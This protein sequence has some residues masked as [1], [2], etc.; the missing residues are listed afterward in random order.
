MPSKKVAK[1]V[2]L[3]DSPISEVSPAPVYS[4]HIPKLPKL[5]NRVVF[6]LILAIVIV[7]GAVNFKHLAVAA[8]V[9][10]KPI[11]RLALIRDLEKQSGKQALDNIITKQLILQEA[12]KQGMAVTKE[13]I[14]SKIATTK[15][16]VEAQGAK[17]DDI[18]ASQG[19][20]QRDLEDQFSV[21]LLI[22]KILSKDIKVE[23][24]EIS[25]YFKTNTSFFPKGTKLDEVKDSIRD[26]L[27]QQKINQKFQEWVTELKK[28]AKIDYWL[29]L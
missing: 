9:N 21:Q 27:T 15:K 18:L 12:A 10:G 8:I 25:D 23:D 1:K 2:D 5:N 29:R 19:I 26:T 17:W 11:S 13:E 28:N 3:S 22:E 20:T 16:Q 24:P 7:L 14:D 6:L 4:N